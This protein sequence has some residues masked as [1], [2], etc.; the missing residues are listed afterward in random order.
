M[1]PADVN[2][3][4]GPSIRS[5]TRHS[6]RPVECRPTRSCWSGLPTRSALSASGPSQ[7]LTA[8]R[9]SPA[10]AC[11]VTMTRWCVLAT[12]S[13]M[14]ESPLRAAARGIDLVMYG[15]LITGFA[16]GQPRPIQIEHADDVRSAGCV[17]FP[18]SRRRG[19]ATSS[20]SQCVQ[21]SRWGGHFSGPTSMS[22]KV[23]EAGAAGR[24]RTPRL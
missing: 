9:G 10:S 3:A 2:R 20:F 21:S 16:P 12:S 13:T 24:L 22:T 6:P 4:K 11:Q 1:Q 15:R 8:Q 17:R 5:M 18:T 23:F 14:P 19:A 7:K